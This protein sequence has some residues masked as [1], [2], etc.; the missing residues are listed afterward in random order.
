MGIVN[1]FSI[2]DMGGFSQRCFKQ[3]SRYFKNTARLFIDDRRSLN[4]VEV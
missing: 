3:H 1:Y 4:Q 2:F